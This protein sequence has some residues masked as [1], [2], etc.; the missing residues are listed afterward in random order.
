MP[1]EFEFF[2]PLRQAQKNAALSSL[3]SAASHNF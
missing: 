3:E 2:Q 1:C